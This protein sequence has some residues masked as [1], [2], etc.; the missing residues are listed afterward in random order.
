MAT[1]AGWDLPTSVPNE[2]PTDER[3]CI[4]T[5]PIVTTSQNTNEKLLVNVDKMAAVDM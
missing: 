4:W 3:Y 2:K 1:L 5:Q